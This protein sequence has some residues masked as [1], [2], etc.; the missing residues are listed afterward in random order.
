MRTVYCILSTLY[1]TLCNA[2]Y[3]YSELVLCNTHGA[4]YT[5]Y[6]MHIMVCKLCLIN[7]CALFAAL[8]TVTVYYTMCPVHCVSTAVR[9][10]STAHQAS[11]IMSCVHEYWAVHCLLRDLSCDRITSLCSVFYALCL[12]ECLLSKPQWE[13]MQGTIEMDILWLTRLQL[14][15]HICI[16]ECVW[17]FVCLFSQ[18]S[19]KVVNMMLVEIITGSCRRWPLCGTSM[20]VVSSISA[21]TRRCLYPA[22]LQWFQIDYDSYTW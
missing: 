12:E 20:S 18:R 13:A 19:H 4:L 21:E 2:H 7:C 6:C 3:A 14:N 22:A 16:S 17:L 8:C 1:S 9:W 10:L 11:R 5:H 15:T